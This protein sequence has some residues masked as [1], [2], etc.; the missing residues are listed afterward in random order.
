MGLFNKAKKDI[1]G[2]LYNFS[3][4]ERDAIERCM[5]V[6]N[7][8]EQAIKGQEQLIQVIR[9]LANKRIGLE[10]TRHTQPNFQTFTFF[11]PEIPI[12]QMGPEEAKP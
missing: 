6:I 11:V 7:F 8:S 3:K 1:P 12:P 4:E 10:A 5:T 9:Q 2:K